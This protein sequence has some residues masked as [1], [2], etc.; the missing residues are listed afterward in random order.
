MDIDD[1]MVP[2][3]IAPLE[4]TDSDQ[5]QYSETFSVIWETA[6]R[7]VDKHSPLFD[8]RRSLHSLKCTRCN[9]AI[10]LVPS[11]FMANMKEL[12]TE[13]R[14]LSDN[15]GNYGMTVSKTDICRDYPPIP[16]LPCMQGMELRRVRPFPRARNVRLREAQG[17]QNLQNSLVL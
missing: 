12:V 3:T 17:R 6:Q 2:A 4:S 15:V 11:N 9:S 8:F 16:S 5:A 7:P 1:E 13:H 10:K 14:R